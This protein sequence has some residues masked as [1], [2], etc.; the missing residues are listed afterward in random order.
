M[1]VW[2]MECMAVINRASSD[3]KLETKPVKTTKRQLNKT[4][5]LGHLQGKRKLIWE[6]ESCRN[7]REDADIGHSCC[8][9]CQSRNSWSVM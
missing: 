2:A 4:S 9:F 8:F 5:H 7:N 6:W 3:R 1:V